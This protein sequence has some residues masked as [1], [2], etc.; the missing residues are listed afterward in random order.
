MSRPVREDPIS[1]PR[2]ARRA[3]RWQELR[4]LVVPERVELD[5]IARRLSRAH[6]IAGLRA[7]ARRRTPRAVFDYVD[8]AADDE[9]SL[10]RA[11]RTFADVEFRPRVLRDVSAADTSTT[12]LGTRAELPLVFAPTGFTRMMHPAGESA[13]ARV[14]ARLGIPYTL[15]TLGTTSPEE[16]AAAAPDSRR[17]FQVYVWRDRAAVRELVDRV[18]DN[19]FSALMLTVDT[20]IAGARRRDARN[21][22]TVPP[23]LTLRTVLD[24]A[25]HPSWWLNVLTTEP[26]HLASFAATG[27]SMGDLID[28]VM[29]PAL[30]VDDLAMLREMW[31]GPLVVKGI[32]TV[33]DARMVVDLGVD[34]IVI[35]NHGGRQ[36]DRSPTPLEVLPEILE[37]VGDRAE[38]YLDGGIMN[39]ADVVA[40]VALGARACLVGRAYLYGLMAGGE[41]GVERAGQILQADIERTLKLLGARSID[42]LEPSQVRLRHREGPRP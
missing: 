8:G 34:A 38:V 6:T 1:Y 40:A 33:E 35:S 32:Q 17:W 36:L 22:L 7:I 10:A 19:G 24:I 31:S 4:A 12:I 14:A 3:P 41:R 5:P 18:R 21:G 23:S 27:L 42:E 37:A 26:L 15:S 25:Q 16:L 13:V 11:R 28:R 29:D 39:G 9:I 20:P 30:N 2:L